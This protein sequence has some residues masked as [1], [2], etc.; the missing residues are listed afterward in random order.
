MRVSSSL[1]GFEPSD[2]HFPTKQML[3]LASAV[4]AS[5]IR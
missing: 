5:A 4:F 2:D 1:N 3:V